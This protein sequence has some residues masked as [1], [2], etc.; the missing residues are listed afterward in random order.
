MSGIYLEWIG[1]YGPR[2][3]PLHTIVTVIS[4]FDTCFC[5][6]GQTNNAPES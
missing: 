4:T 2:F 3:K 1:Y 6:C 5:L